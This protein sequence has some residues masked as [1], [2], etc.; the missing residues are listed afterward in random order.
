MNELKNGRIPLIFV[1]R[2]IILSAHNER[3]SW[4][5]QPF[6]SCPSNLRRNDFLII[7]SDLSSSALPSFSSNS[8]RMDSDDSNQTVFNAISNFNNSEVETPDEFFEF[9]PSPTI[10]SQPP[11]QT[12]TPPTEPITP[13]TEPIPPPT[14]PITPP[15]EPSLSPFSH[16]D[17][18]RILYPLSISEPDIPSPIADDQ[19]E[20]DLDENFTQQK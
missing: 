13:P 7:F 2:T 16:T 19:F 17:A 15:V 4:I 18:T 5:P 10:F 14:Q 11:I 12:I 20:H 1:F 3:T 8:P 9:E 6:F